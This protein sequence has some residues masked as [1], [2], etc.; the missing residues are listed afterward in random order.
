MFSP[1]PF[2]CKPAQLFPLFNVFIESSARVMVTLPK[3]SLVILNAAVLS[4]AETSIFTPARV[5]SALTS[6][7]TSIRSVVDV[8][9]F[10]FFIVSGVSD[11]MVSTLF[12]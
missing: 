8:D 3:L 7:A 12:S 2:F 5:I 9:G 1:P 6:L 11:M 10:V 4:D